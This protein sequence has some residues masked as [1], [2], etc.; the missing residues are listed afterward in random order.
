MAVS[1]HL[2]PSTDYVRVAT[3]AMIQLECAGK[4]TYVLL[5]AA[6]SINSRQRDVLDSVDCYATEK[7][8]RLDRNYVERVDG[9][10]ARRS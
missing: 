9:D 1:I 6:H 7:S 5:E 2:S 3:R 8:S 10:R 4:K